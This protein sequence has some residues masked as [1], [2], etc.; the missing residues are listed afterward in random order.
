MTSRLALKETG[1]PASV[2][3]TAKRSGRVKHGRSRRAE[4]WMS[5]AAVSLSVTVTDAGQRQAALLTLQRRYVSVDQTFTRIQPDRHNAHDE[6]T[7][8]CLCVLDVSKA[9]TN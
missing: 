3:V 4:C 6:Q 7:Q 8:T 2:G 1:R 9:L 5:S